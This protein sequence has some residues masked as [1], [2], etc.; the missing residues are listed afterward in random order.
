[1]AALSKLFGEKFLK[2]RLFFPGKELVSQGLA[3]PALCAPSLPVTPLTPSPQDLPALFL[4]AIRLPFKKRQPELTP[5]LPATTFVR[6]PVRLSTVS[7]APLLMP[8]LLL[9]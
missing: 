5:P 4:P 8:S 9:V 3:N 7:T 1:M 6:P 2:Q